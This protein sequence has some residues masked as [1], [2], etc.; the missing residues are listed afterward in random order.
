MRDVWLIF[1]LS[2]PL[3]FF[4]PGVI[5]LAGLSGALVLLQLAWLAWRMLVGQ[6]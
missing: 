5:W 6:G 4:V 2:V 1:L 3:S